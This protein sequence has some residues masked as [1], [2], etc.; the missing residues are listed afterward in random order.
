M[1][2]IAKGP[3]YAGLFRV[4]YLFYVSLQII[5]NYLVVILG[6]EFVEDVLNVAA[7]ID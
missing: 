5:Q 7:F 2:N 3:Q 6:F 1:K 4:Y